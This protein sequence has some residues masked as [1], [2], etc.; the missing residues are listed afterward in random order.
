MDSVLLKL[1]GSSPWTS[2]LGYLMAIL[3]VVKPII[4]KG[5]F[6]FKRDWINLL[7]A[8]L[9][10]ITGR[11]AKDTNG[12]KAVEGLAMKKALIAPTEEEEEI[13]PEPV[14]INEA[15]AAVAKENVP[16]TVKK[17]TLKPKSG[18]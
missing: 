12:V 16:K 17:K 18:T 1:F 11:Q 3:A 2:I 6:D 15:V 7:F 4:E 5:D 9:V 8:V 10:A 13:E 14:K